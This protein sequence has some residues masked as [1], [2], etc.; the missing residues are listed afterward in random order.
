M[1]FNIN[2]RL[3]LNC[4]VRARDADDRRT[5][6]QTCTVHTHNNCGA[7]GAIPNTYSIHRLTEKPSVDIDGVYA[8]SLTLELC[9]GSVCMC[10]FTRTIAY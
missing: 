9:G 1:Y 4:C 8:G 5:L 2:I 7:R 6:R 3:P 10:V